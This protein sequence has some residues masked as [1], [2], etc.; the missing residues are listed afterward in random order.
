[1]NKNV[2]FVLSIMIGAFAAYYLGAMFDF[3]IFLADD[4]AVRAIGY[5]TVVICTVI[6][7]CTCIIKD[8]SENKDKDN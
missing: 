3:G 7:I 5:C 2:K 8:K 4:F 6:A 1:M